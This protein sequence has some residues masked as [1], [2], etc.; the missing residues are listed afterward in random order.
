MAM[1]MKRPATC[2]VLLLAG[3]ALGFGICGMSAAAQYEPAPTPPLSNITTPKEALGFNLGDDYHM[4]S[5]TQLESYW[6]KLA[7]QSN[8]L[9]LVDIGLTAEGRHQYMM[10]ISSPANMKNLEHYKEISRKLAL[11]K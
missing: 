7:S 10:I 8:R 3:A 6:K 4:A 11:A 1:F 5:Y 9:K 2:S